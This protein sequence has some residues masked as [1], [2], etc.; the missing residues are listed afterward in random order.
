MPKATLSFKLPEEREEHKQAL[1]GPAYASALE[2]MR[3]Y[4]R[5]RLKYEE[6]MPH[7]ARTA[8]EAARDHLS[9]LMMDIED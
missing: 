7:D 2:E 4:F 3:S 8:L 1:N 9:G 5:N 6:A